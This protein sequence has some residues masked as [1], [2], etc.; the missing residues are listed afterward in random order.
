MKETNGS[1]EKIL[2]INRVIDEITFQTN[3]LAL[4]LAIEAAGAGDA[5]GEVGDLTQ[6]SADLRAQTEGLQTVLESLCE[7]PGV[8]V[9]GK[10]PGG[11]RSPKPALV[12]VPPL[13]ASRFPLNENGV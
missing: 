5:A 1:S 6:R 13:R 7:L 11:G 9:Q 12:A 4:H 3:L 2:R 8:V 10:M